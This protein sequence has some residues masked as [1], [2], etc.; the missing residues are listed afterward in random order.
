MAFIFQ[1]TTVYQLQRKVKSLREA[2][3]RK[4]LHLD[5]LRRKFAL[6]EEATKAAKVLEDEKDDILAR[7]DN[8]TV[9]GN[10]IS[11]P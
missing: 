7:F 9:N 2:V 1:T 6:N 5:M 8:S 11:P 3:D 10:F 4:E